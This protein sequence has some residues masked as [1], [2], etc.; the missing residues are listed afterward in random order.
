MKQ[1]AAKAG[2][3]NSVDLVQPMEKGVCEVFAGVTIDPTFGPAVTFGMGGIF[4]EI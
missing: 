3:P 4:I 2:F 1:Q